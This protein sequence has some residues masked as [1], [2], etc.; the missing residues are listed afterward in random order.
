MGSDTVQQLTR[1]GRCAEHAHKG[2][3]SAA[4]TASH[5]APRLCLALFVCNHSSTKVQPVKPVNFHSYLKS[6]RLSSR[7]GSSLKAFFPGCSVFWDH[8]KEGRS[9]PTGDGVQLRSLGH[10]R[11]CVEPPVEGGGDCSCRAGCNLH[12]AFMFN[13]TGFTPNKTQNIIHETD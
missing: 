5:V 13:L 4:R 7:S 10:E 8:S 6:T 9:S 3:K 12:R 11:G 2:D 1:R